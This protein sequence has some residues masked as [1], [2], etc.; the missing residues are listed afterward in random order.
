MLTK[1]HFLNHCFSSSCWI[2]YKLLAF[3]P[4][5]K[6]DSTAGV[7]S[8]AESMCFPLAPERD[9]YSYCC[10]SDTHVFAVE[11]DHS[12]NTNRCFKTRAIFRSKRCFK[13]LRS[14]KPSKLNILSSRVLPK[15]KLHQA[16]PLSES[17]GC[18]LYN[19]SIITNGRRVETWV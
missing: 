9:C 10:C 11:E 15:N 18:M 3:H 17:F 5:V 7:F 14:I 4:A 8:N 16:Y 19:L 1:P 6:H 12:G 2:K 13:T